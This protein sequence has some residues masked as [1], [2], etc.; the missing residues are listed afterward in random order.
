MKP[1]KLVLE[2]GDV[3]EGISFGYDKDAGGEVVFNTA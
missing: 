1:A 2:S 3:F